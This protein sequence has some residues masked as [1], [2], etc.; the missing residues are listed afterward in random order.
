[1]TVVIKSHGNNI[2][3]TSQSHKYSSNFY[4]ISSRE[5][6]SFQKGEI[7]VEEIQV[8]KIKRRIFCYR[9]PVVC[10]TKAPPTK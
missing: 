4:I 8:Q 1:M 7:R 10:G 2:L 6:T 3:Y 9:L 5:E